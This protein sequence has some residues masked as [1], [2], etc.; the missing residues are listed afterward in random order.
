MDFIYNGTKLYYEDFGDKN[1][2]NIV[3]FFNGLMATTESWCFIYP[4]FLKAGFR[5]VLFDFKGQIKSDKPKGP[6]SFAELAEE[7]LA[8]MKYLGLEEPHL[9][10]TSFGG[11]V[12][13]KLAS[14]FPDFAKT[15]SIIDSISEVDNEFMEVMLKNQQEVL[16]GKTVYQVLLPFCYSKQYFE[17][18][19]AFFEQAA[20]K[21]DEVEPEI[22]AGQITLGETFFSEVDMTPDLKKIICPCLVVCGEEDSFTPRRFSQ[23]I[24]DNISNSEYVL[25]PNCGHTSIF[26]KPK[27]LTSVVLGFVSKNI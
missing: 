24:S 1:S 22:L 8:L 9:I 18:N 2:K 12:L 14:L 7:S 21:M 20:P 27:E 19:K 13:M 5:V 23:I 11:K 26:E 25:I 4:Q 16:A 17:K 15:I 10:G 3:V 6:Y